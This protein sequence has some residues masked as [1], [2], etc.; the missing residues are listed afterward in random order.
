MPADDSPHEVEPSLRADR[1]VARVTIR[2]GPAYGDW[3][4]SGVGVG[5]DVLAGGVAADGVG[6]PDGLAAA[7]R[8]AEGDVGAWLLVCPP[9]IGAV[10]C[11]GMGWE[12]GGSFRTAGL[13][14]SSR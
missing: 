7:D 12:T 10:E 4:G 2:H 8:V 3:V 11:T 13:G 9:G 5:L 14:R 1:T 6:V